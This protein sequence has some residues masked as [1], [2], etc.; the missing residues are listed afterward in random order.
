MSVFHSFGR[1]EITLEET[2]YGIILRSYLASNPIYEKL[3]LELT[4]CIYTVRMDTDQL[5]HRLCQRWGV[6]IFCQTQAVYIELLSPLLITADEIE[7][8][9]WIKIGLLFRILNFKFYI[10]DNNTHMFLVSVLAWIRSNKIKY[11]I[12]LK[13]K[14]FCKIR[15]YFR[16]PLLD[17]IQMYLFPRLCTLDQ[18]TL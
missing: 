12:H 18:K 3:T 13:L 11:C 16:Y 10:F 1:E 9:V 6:S 4:W 8:T 17:K 2:Y 5:Q 15:V 14:G 7:F